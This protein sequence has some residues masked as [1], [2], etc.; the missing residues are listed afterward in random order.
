MTR[1]I[2]LLLLFAFL[3]YLIKLIIQIILPFLNKN[4]N[5]NLF[6]N[7]SKYNKKEGDVTIDHIPKKEKKY[8][9]ED[10]KYVDYKEIN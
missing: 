2:L 7:Y 1:F 5:Y 10:G 3:Y 9:K 8:N 4:K 6:H